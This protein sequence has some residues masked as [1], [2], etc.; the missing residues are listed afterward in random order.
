[1][2]NVLKL[3][4][5]GSDAANAGLKISVLRQK[6]SGVRVSGIVRLNG[7]ECDGQGMVGR[8]RDGGH[9]FFEERGAVRKLRKGGVGKC[10]CMM[11]L[12]GCAGTVERGE[13]GE[14]W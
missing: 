7:T 1:M 10:C 13:G 2:L 12:C 4:G 8:R 6:N 14:T 3:S 5:H 11:Q 9:F